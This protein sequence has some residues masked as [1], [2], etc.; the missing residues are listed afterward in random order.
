MIRKKARKNESLTEDIEKYQ[1]YYFD[2]LIDNKETSFIDFNDLLIDMKR[3]YRWL[4]KSRNYRDYLYYLYGGAYRDARMAQPITS[5]TEF[6]EETN[7]IYVGSK[8]II[9]D[10]MPYLGKWY[11]EIDG[12]EKSGEV[13]FT[14]D[15]D[16][17]ETGTVRGKSKYAVEKKSDTIYW[18]R[19]DSWNL[20]EYN[21][22]TDTLGFITPENGKIDIYGYR[23]NEV[24]QVIVTI[25]W[26]Y[27]SYPTEFV[28]N[29]GE[30]F[31]TIYVTEDSIVI[32]DSTYDGDPLY[33]DI[34]LTNVSHLTIELM[35]SIGKFGDSEYYYSIDS[36]F[37]VNRLGEGHNFYFTI[38]ENYQVFKQGWIEM[39]SYDLNENIRYMKVHFDD[40]TIGDI[41]YSYANKTMWLNG[42]A[43]IETTSIFKGLS[44][45]GDYYNKE[46]DKTIVMLMMQRSALLILLLTIAQLLHSLIYL[47]YHSETK[48][49]FEY[50]DSDI[51][52]NR[53]IYSVVLEMSE[54]T[55]TLIVDGVVY[56]QI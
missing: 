44:F 17:I 6:L 54:G 50:Y 22:E 10:V 3:C 41:R 11:R 20:V 51:N 19:Y 46:L 16:G 38:Y 28:V 31:E 27:S 53:L 26:N 35:D 45:V 56:N 1:N 39:T 48:W 21:L 18:I 55:W 9:D 13:Y 15:A 30:S 8:P 2:Y 29:K 49:S 32:L 42:E 24:T 25:K 47:L 7:H 4:L 37:T 12:K 52:G 14:I 5:T 23:Y 36:A 34:S 33:E 40:G 43:K